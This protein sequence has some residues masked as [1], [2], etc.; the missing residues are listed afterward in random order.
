MINYQN[1]LKFLLEV[2]DDFSPKLSQKVELSDFTTKVLDKAHCVFENGEKQDIIGV[3][4][5]YANDKEKRYSYISLVAVGKKYRK[6][7]VAKR[8]LKQYVEYA[9]SIPY[10]DTIGIHTNNPIALKMYMELGFV[11]IEEINKRYYLEYKVR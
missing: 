7:G 8:L 6:Q 3:V 11:V 1:L 2:D 4:V 9:S 10:I 5:G